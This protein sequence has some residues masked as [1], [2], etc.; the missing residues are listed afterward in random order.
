MTN[1]AENA[2]LPSLAMFAPAAPMRWRPTR[3]WCPSS[4]TTCSYHFMKVVMP[5]S[6]DAGT[7]APLSMT[8]Q[9]SNKE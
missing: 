4:A 3:G 1:I 8:L 7:D 6:A 5:V 9:Q 2:Q